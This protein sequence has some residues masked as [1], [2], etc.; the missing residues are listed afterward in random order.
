M[1]GTWLPKKKH[2]INKCKKKINEGLNHSSELL[3]TY[4]YQNLEFKCLTGHLKYWVVCSQ[5]VFH[6]VPQREGATDFIYLTLFSVTLSTLFSCFKEA[7][8]TE[9]RWGFQH[10]SW[11]D[12]LRM[13]QK[14]HQ[15]WDQTDTSGLHEPGKL[16]WSYMTSGLSWKMWLSLKEFLH[17]T[18]ETW[19]H[20]AAACVPRA[21]V[22]ASSRSRSVFPG[23]PVSKKVRKNNFRLNF[24]SN[25]AVNLNQKIFKMF[26]GIHSL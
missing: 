20:E 8:T 17:H 21:G 5:I 15:A 24:Q 19:I 26:K 9:R 10:S 7:V 4:N 18:K 23:F 13:K 2:A 1:V 16:A 12:I 6:L 11:K 22:R 25:P 3:I 14:E